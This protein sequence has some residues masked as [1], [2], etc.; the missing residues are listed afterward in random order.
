VDLIAR[1]R[2]SVVAHL[3][4]DLTRELVGWGRLAETLLTLAPGSRQLDNLPELTCDLLVLDKH[5]AAHAVRIATDEPAERIFELLVQRTPFPARVVQTGGG[6]DQTYL[7]DRQAHLSW[8]VRP[9]DL[10]RLPR[11][12]GGWLCTTGC[13]DVVAVALTWG[14]VEGLNLDE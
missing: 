7:Y 5:E 8:L 11:P 1:S 9:A 14:L 12:Q 3:P 2:G 10:G 13:G 6:G 4:L